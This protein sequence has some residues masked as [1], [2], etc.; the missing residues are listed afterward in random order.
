MNYCT[1]SDCEEWE[2]N[3]EI[4]NIRYFNPGKTQRATGWK[5]LRSNKPIETCFLCYSFTF[6]LTLSEN[7]AVAV[8]VDVLQWVL[9]IFVWWLNTLTSPS[10]GHGRPFWGNF[11][12][13][14]LFFW[15]PSANLHSRGSA[16][17]TE[18][19]RQRGRQGQTHRGGFIILIAGKGELSYVQS[20]ISKVRFK[21]SALCCGFNKKT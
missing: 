1:Y 8:E 7:A 4:E 6:P 15:P 2:A 12:W 19:V 14:C 20:S 21:Y 3:A 18:W 17:A 5:G 16:G 10:R 13:V 11:T 9:L